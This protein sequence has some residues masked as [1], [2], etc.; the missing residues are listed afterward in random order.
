MEGNKAQLFDSL[1][2]MAL[3]VL[4]L[5]IGA[6]PNI[7]YYAKRPDLSIIGVD[8]NQHM[9][10]YARAAASAAGLQDSQ[11]KFVQ[12]VSLFS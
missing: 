5:G 8:P 12:A 6:G 4:E 3:D 10:K 9:E 2:D 7:K 11:F 1:G